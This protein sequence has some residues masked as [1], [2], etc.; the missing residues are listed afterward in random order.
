MLRNHKKTPLERVVLTALLAVS[1]LASE[2]I[3]TALWS[4]PAFAKGGGN[5]GGNGGGGGGGGGGKGGGG[6]GG[7]GNAGGNGGGSSG[8]NAGGNGKGKGANSP[9]ASST[10]KPETEVEANSALGLREAGVIRSLKEVYNVAE[11]QLHGR[12]LDAK[13]VGSSVSG[14]DYDLRV[15]TEDGHVREARYDATT[16]ALEALDGQP[17]E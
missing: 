3:L 12:V 1:L 17:I 8:S 14:W 11:K 15:V 7:G 13:L 16:L 5:G 4:D 6:G 2:A 10:G 9:G